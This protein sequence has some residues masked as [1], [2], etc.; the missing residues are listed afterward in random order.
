MKN[1]Q[2]VVV[3]ILTL[4]VGLSIGGGVSF[5]AINKKKEETKVVA[6]KETTSLPLNT[7]TVAQN[8]TNDKL[9]LNQEP[10]KPAAMAEEKWTGEITLKPKNKELLSQIITKPQIAEYQIG[11]CGAG[12]VRYYLTTNSNGNYN[13]PTLEITNKNIVMSGSQK[14]SFEKI[15]NFVKS[16]KIVKTEFSELLPFSNIVFGGMCENDGFSSLSGNVLDNIKIL[17]N[18]MLDHA[19]TFN[20]TVYATKGEYLLRYQNKSKINDSV[21][22]KIMDDCQAERNNDPSVGQDLL[23]CIERKNLMLPE[24]EKLAN[25]SIQELLTIFAL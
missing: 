23:D 16:E 19:I 18:E 7:A 20:N 6:G 1:W 8:R 17:K 11:N 3:V 12:A 2:I 15:Y 24:Y 10:V 22:K 4:I 13:L 21:S 14:T 25:D 9:I 5:I